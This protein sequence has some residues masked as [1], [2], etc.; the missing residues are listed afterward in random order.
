MKKNLIAA[1]FC[2]LII[3]S[4]A[5]C[6]LLFP[7]EESSAPQES[8]SVSQEAAQED[9][10]RQAVADAIAAFKA[11]DSQ[12]I[13]QLVRFT[14]SEITLAGHTIQ[15]KNNQLFPE[16]EELDETTRKLVQAVTANMECEITD[17]QQN[18]DTAQVT[19]DITALDLGALVKD[20]A[21]KAI[22]GNT[23]ELKKLEDLSYL[24]D[25]ISQNGDKTAVRSVTFSMEK[26]DGQWMLVL[27]G[28]IV[29]TMMGGMISTLSQLLG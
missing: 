8:S 14:D 5:G 25:Y 17:L 9:G 18:G 10:P 12:K 15:V 1:V 22:T 19:A 16:G 3:G 4:L 26:V 11:V 23:E 20:L 24:A 6:G 29:D 28:T 21:V 13:N 7:K 2:L 27:D